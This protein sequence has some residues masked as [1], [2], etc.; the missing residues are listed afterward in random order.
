MSDYNDLK[1]LCVSN[2]QEEFY[3]SKTDEN[4]LRVSDDSVNDVQMIRALERELEIVERLILICPLSQR[5]KW[6][7]EKDLLLDEL[8]KY[9]LS[10]KY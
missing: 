10:S 1:C 8:S 3:R 7:E 6:L 4:A 2:L 5:D 9:P